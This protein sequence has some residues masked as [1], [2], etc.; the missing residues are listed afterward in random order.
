MIL[1]PA[2]LALAIG[3]AVPASA[4][5]VDP[6]RFFEGRTESVGTVKIAMQKPFRSR[7]VGK[8]EILADGSL[9]LVQRIE[10]EG[11]LAHE[12]RWTMRK[13]SP[14]RYTGRMSEARGPVTVEEVGGNYR[15]RFR[16]Q[17]NVA[18]E[19]WLIPAADGRSARSKVTIRKYGVRV[20]GS[21]GVIRKL[22][23]LPSVASAAPPTPRPSA[24]LRAPR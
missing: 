16:M 8:G 22:D 15:F 23:Q 21:D 6:M 18:V 1:R 2:V 14:G 7:A 13:V 4:Q 19:Q 17:G 24:A 5:E 10:D 11:A 20:G 12:R 9:K 3:L